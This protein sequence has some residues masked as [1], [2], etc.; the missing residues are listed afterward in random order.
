MALTGALLGLPVNTLKKFE[1]QFRNWFLDKI[2][3]LVIITTLGDKICSIPISEIGMPGVFS[4]DL[5]VALESN[6]LDIVVHSLKDLPTNIGDETV[7]CLIPER[8]NPYDVA[9]LNP[10]Y[11][12]LSEIPPRGVIGTSS[13]RRRAQIKALYPHF[14]VQDIRGNLKTRIMK[15]KN[16]NTYDALVLAKAGIIRSKFKHL[17]LPNS[18][19]YAA[20]Q[21][22]ALACANAGHNL[23]NDILDSGGRGILDNILHNH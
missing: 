8:E 17:S 11:N 20:G 18:F 14:I 4:N 13:P 19:L 21:T 16:D 2:Y 15:L 12:A 5:S 9:I 1:C 23:A 6:Q 3:I 22:A 7:I 10:K